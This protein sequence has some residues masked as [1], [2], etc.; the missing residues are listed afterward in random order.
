MAGTAYTAMR[1]FKFCISESTYLIETAVLCCLLH[2]TIQGM[3]SAEGE[4]R[5]H[6]PVLAIPAMSHA[7]QHPMCL[8]R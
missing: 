7:L 8:R 1:N 3:R 6:G 5:S 2:V 4:P